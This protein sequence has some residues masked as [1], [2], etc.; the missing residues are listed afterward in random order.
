MSLWIKKY[1]RAD[2]RGGEISPDSTRSFGTLKQL[3]A[4]L[5]QLH[6]TEDTLGFL[7]LHPSFGI[8]LKYKVIT[9]GCLPP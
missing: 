5:L 3:I 4:K 8:Y 7:E 6:F 1:L 2:R 9:H